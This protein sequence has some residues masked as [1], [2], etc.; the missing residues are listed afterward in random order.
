[1][2][3]GELLGGAAPRW[4]RVQV[5][6]T[7]DDA[8]ALLADG[9][10]AI[11]TQLGEALAARGDVDT[12]VLPPALVHAAARVPSAAAAPGAPGAPTTE[13]P[14]TCASCNASCINNF[15]WCLF[16]P[17]IGPFCPIWL[18]QCQTN[19]WTSGMCP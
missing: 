1:V 13:S 8:R 19:C 3:A 16:T 17:F 2:P 5:T 9:P 11:A 7:L 12:S 18:S 15:N 4:E 6:G 14:F 10:L